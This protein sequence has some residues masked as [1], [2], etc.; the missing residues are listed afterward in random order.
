MENVINEIAKK[1]YEIHY[2]KG[3]ELEAVIELNQ[4][5]KVIGGQT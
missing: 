1:L 5:I 3:D 2:H 4:A